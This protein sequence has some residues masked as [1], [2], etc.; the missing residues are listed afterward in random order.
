M[1]FTI[2]RTDVQA[3]G[4]HDDT[5]EGDDFFATQRVRHEL[6]TKLWEVL[7]PKEKE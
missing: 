2:V 5:A 6:A 4:H 7:F 1:A 3:G